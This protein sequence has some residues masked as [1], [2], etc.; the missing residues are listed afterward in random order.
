[1]DEIV[2]FACYNARMV[3]NGQILE[4][5]L[6]QILRQAP[7][8]ENRHVRVIVDDEAL[9]NSPKGAELDQLLDEIAG[10]VQGSLPDDFS[11]DDI[12]GDHD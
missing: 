8:L 7:E 12:Y 4:G 6:G 1:M 10:P 11:R 2:V 5:T 3:R 9:A